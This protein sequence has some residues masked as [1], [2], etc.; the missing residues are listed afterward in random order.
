MNLRSALAT[1]E[2]QVKMSYTARP[3][4][5]NKQ[6]TK[7]NQ[8]K[9]IHCSWLHFGEW[10]EERGKGSDRPLHWTEKTSMMAWTNRIKREV[11]GSC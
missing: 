8:T 5:K 3:L 4:F 10:V 11:L 6:A 2:F 1:Y 7:P 9:T